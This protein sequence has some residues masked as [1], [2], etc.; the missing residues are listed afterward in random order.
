MPGD[1]TDEHYINVFDP[2]YDSDQNFTNIGNTPICVVA[3]DHRIYK[4]QTLQ[5]NVS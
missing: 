4:K 1:Y 3:E 5:I 2:T